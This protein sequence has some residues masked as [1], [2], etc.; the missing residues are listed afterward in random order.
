MQVTAQS[1]LALPKVSDRRLYFLN[2]VQDHDLEHLSRSRSLQIVA[3]IFIFAL[4]NPFY[5]KMK[6]RGTTSNNFKLDKYYSEHNPKQHLRGF[7]C[8]SGTLG[9]TGCGAGTSL[10]EKII[11]Q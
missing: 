9:N 7:N 10:F 1:A 3:L 2:I 5:V 4:K 11:K 6:V 8:R